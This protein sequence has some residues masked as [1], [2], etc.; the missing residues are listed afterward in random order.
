[1]RFFLLTTF[2]PLA[3]GF[4]SPS[5]CPTGTWQDQ[6]GACHFGHGP[7]DPIYWIDRNGNRISPNSNFPFGSTSYTYTLPDGT[8]VT[9]ADRRYRRG[10]NPG[11]FFD[12]KWRD[13]RDIQ[14]LRDVRGG[15]PYL[16]GLDWRFAK[17]MRTAHGVISSMAF[18]ILFPLGAIVVNLGPGFVGTGLHLGFQILGWLFYLVGAAAG[19][20]MASAIRW[21]GFSF[22]S[23]L[24]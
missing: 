10:N 9:Q 7:G 16:A 6:N 13:R 2:L 24:L 19:L 11:T 3:L 14:P 12:A 20:W 21:R 8:K 15:V 4:P 1:M 18:V 5:W 23:F 22:V 17:H